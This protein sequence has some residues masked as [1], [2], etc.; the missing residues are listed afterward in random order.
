LHSFVEYGWAY[1]CHVQGG[2]ENVHRIIQEIHVKSILVIGNVLGGN[3]VLRKL[4]IN[5]I[6][7]ADLQEFAECSQWKKFKCR[8]FCRERDAM[9]KRILDDI[10]LLHNTDVEDK[11]KAYST[12][13]ELK[14]WDMPYRDD[15]FVE[16]I[17]QSCQELS[18]SE[19]DCK[20]ANN[21]FTSVSTEEYFDW[22][23]ITFDMIYEMDQRVFDCNR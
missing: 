9:M 22:L 17:Y 3:H 5:A 11:D 21:R 19:M 8:V 14:R 15:K 12:W 18:E 6:D 4:Y 1:D 10:V 20:Y 23:G 13:E 16:S 2:S 7:T